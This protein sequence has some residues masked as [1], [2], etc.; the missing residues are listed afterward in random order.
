LFYIVLTGA[1][2]AP[3]TSIVDVFASYIPS[4]IAD[5]ETVSNFFNQYL[6]HKFNNAGE[7]HQILCPVLIVHGRKD[8]V[9]SF[10]LGEKLFHIR[11][12]I[13]SLPSFFCPVE[14]ALHINTMVF[15]ET[16]KCM[17]EF[18]HEIFSTKKFSNQ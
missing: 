5:K 12:S 18:W 10:E 4:F 6:H 2:Q 15:D 3:F 16:K 17:T 9:V 11:Q 1:L 8:N 7:I 14:D 13:K